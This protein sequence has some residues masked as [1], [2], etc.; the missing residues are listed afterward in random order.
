MRNI[1]NFFRE[2]NNIA[3]QVKNGVVDIRDI[4]ARENINS[5][6][7]R[8]TAPTFLTPYIG[9]EKTRKVLA[10][11]HINVPH[12]GFMEGEIGYVITPIDQFGVKFGQRDNGQFVK[13][14]EVLNDLTHGPHDQGE[15]TLPDSPSIDSVDKE[16]YSL[17]FEWQLS[18]CGMFQVFSHI[19]D[20]DELDEILEDI[21]G[22]YE[23]DGE[24]IDNMNEETLN[25]LKTSTYKRVK[26]ELKKR[27]SMVKR[28]LKD[29][30]SETLSKHKDRYEKSIDRADRL[31]ARKGENPEGKVMSESSKLNKIKKKIAMIKQANVKPEVANDGKAVSKIRKALNRPTVNQFD[32]RNL[33]VAEETLDEVSAETVGKVAGA[34]ALG[35]WKPK[36][37][38]ASKTI[39]RRHKQEW[40]KSEVGKLKK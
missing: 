31:I 1:K 36:T 26:G 24:D 4:D 21:E 35:K 19:V 9:L 10:N 37:E 33:K 8:A 7:M 29:R 38:K 22:E 14:G 18:D 34:K 17:F 15:T 6:L 32:I 12:Q 11:F 39:E 28:G 27:L 5:L 40:L 16:E 25:E 13:D 23:E 3:D 30:D 2:E 20:Q